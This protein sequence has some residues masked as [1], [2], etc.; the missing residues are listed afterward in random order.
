MTGL[1]RRRVDYRKPNSDEPGISPA[2]D[3]EARW[4]Y[5]GVV[6]FTWGQIAP[7]HLNT[8]IFKWVNLIQLSNTHPRNSPA[9]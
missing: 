4:R 7:T 1:G 8:S 2:P 5:F 9:F 6:L 3:S